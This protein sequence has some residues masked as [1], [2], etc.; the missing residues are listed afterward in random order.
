[1]NKLWG[2]IV[3]F[4]QPVRVRRDKL[5]TEEISDLKEFTRTSYF[6]VLIR[7]L[8]HVSTNYRGEAL[9]EMLR[10]DRYARDCLFKAK[11]AENVMTFLIRLNKARSQE[12]FL[13]E[14]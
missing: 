9:E 7:Y 11:G 6:K 4:I 3:N 1:M 2:N 5:N 10:G 12:D 13:K 8:E 14:E